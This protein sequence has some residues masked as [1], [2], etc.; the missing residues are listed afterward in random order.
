MLEFSTRNI[1]QRALL[2]LGLVLTAFLIGRNATAESPPSKVEFNR[3]IRPLLSENC[4]S[5]HGPD[6]N[7]RKAELRLD[8][9]DSALEI[10]AIVP[11]KPDESELVARIMSDDEDE[12][13]P[14]R[15]SHKTLTAD[16]KELL[17][18]WIAQGAEYQAH[19]AYVAPTRQTPPK[20]ERADWGAIRSTLSSS[21]R[22]IRRG[23]NRRPKPPDAR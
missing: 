23:S 17:K 20:V 5:C 9:R 8:H 18:A 13:M 14:P 1:P 22:S 15:E 11:G 19:W 21:P 3:D 6:K 10:E 16:Q 4:Y 7:R 2:V 12:I